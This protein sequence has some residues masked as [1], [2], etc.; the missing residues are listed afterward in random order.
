MNTDDHLLRIT[1]IIESIAGRAVVHIDDLTYGAHPDATQREAGEMALLDWSQTGG[2]IVSEGDDAVLELVRR[3]SPARA[4]GA[5][6][7]AAFNAG[8]AVADHLPLEGTLAELAT[9]RTPAVLIP[10]P[11][12][13]DDHQTANARES[14]RTG[15]A[16][17]LPESELNR[18]AMVVFERLHDNAALA[19]MRDALALADAAN[20]WEALATETVALA[21]G[22]AA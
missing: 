6:L 11:S 22:A 16:I 17:L 21:G 18:L 12:A 9:C 10:L 20:R 15:A 2:P 14:E 4:L 1:G 3:T 5:A 8:A 7:L 19:V 13:A